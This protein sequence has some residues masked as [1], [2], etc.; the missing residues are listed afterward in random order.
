MR[1][2]HALHAAWT[3]KRVSKCNTLLR[4]FHFIDPFVIS[5]L[6]VFL[7]VVFENFHTFV[8]LFGAI[9]FGT[10]EPAQVVIPM[11]MGKQCAVVEKDAAEFG[12]IPI[13]SIPMV[14]FDVFVQFVSVHAKNM[15]SNQ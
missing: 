10:P 6:F 13:R 1:V 4:R 14:L 2:L 15:I 8:R 9:V 11:Q 12:T 5:S 3:C 7:L